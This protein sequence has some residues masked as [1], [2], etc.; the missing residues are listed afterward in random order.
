MYTFRVGRDAEART[1]LSCRRSADCRSGGSALPK[2]KRCQDN[3]F[4]G[5]SWQKQRLCDQTGGGITNRYD[6]SRSN[7]LRLAAASL[8]NIFESSYRS[9]APGMEKATD[10]QRD[11]DSG[12]SPSD[13][14]KKVGVQPGAFETATVSHLPPDPDEG[15]TDAE[16]ADIVKFALYLR[17]HRLKNL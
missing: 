7:P 13:A 4:A 11:S 9:Q 16:K 6:G 8:P 17:C 10:F 14:E 12:H 15:L 3:H 5:S 2:A 1:R